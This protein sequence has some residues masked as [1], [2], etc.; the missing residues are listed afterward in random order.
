ML[1]GNETNNTKCETNDNEEHNYI[2][3]KPNSCSFK[4]EAIIELKDMFKLRNA[5]FDQK[6]HIPIFF[7]FIYLFI[8]FYKTRLKD[9]EDVNSQ[10]EK[11][12]V[13]LQQ[14]TLNA[15][16]RSNELEAH[17]LRLLEQLISILPQ[18]S[19]TS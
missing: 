13:D 19:S 17:K 1:R 7:N 16:N 11:V 8:D 5:E 18:S 2:K 15:L 3:V 14:Q 10:R 4:T 9:M 6:Y 12:S